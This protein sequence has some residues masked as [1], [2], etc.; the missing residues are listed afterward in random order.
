VVSGD[1]AEA[2]V[3]ALRDNGFGHLLLGPDDRV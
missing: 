2:A 3:A 1:D